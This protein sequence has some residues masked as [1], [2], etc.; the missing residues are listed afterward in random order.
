MPV[1]DHRMLTARNVALSV[2]AC[3]ITTLLVTPLRHVLAEANIVMLFLWVV[4]WLSA[5]LGRA[6]GMTAAFCSVALFD[7]FFVEPRFSFSVSDVQYLLTFAVMLVVA[8]SISSLTLHLRERAD[9]AQVLAMQS[10]ALYELAKSLSSSLSVEQVLDSTT[11]FLKNTLQ[12]ESALVL[13]DPKECLHVQGGLDLSPVEV[14]MAH[15]TFDDGL[16]K[17]MGYHNDGDHSSTYL[18]LQGST[19]VRGV[20]VARTLATS[21]D[22][23]LNHRAMLEAVASIVS[24][25]IERLHF[26][27]VAQHA[28]LKMSN[29]RLRSSILSALSHDIRTPLT[30]LYGMADG[31]HF[32]EP[33]L[34]QVVLNTADALCG[35]VMQLNTMVCNLLEMAKFQAGALVLRREWLP[36]EEVI[37]ASIQLLSSA[38]QPHGV[39]VNLPED[40]PLLNVDAVLLERVFCNLLENASKYSPQNDSPFHIHAREVGDDVHV[41][42]DNQGDAI[43]EAQLKTIFKLFE[44]GQVESSVHGTGIGLSICRSIVEAHGGRIWAENLQDGVRMCFS[45][46]IGTPPEVNIIDEGC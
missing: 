3:I 36:I 33:P 2:A 34:P 35:Q 13:P 26:V 38:I 16:I 4:V 9:D 44:R 25:S 21:A 24:A 7:L 28:Q 41:S 10:H 37:G 22:Q 17:E 31:L 40:L 29:E 43:P 14:L 1:I 27:D 45:L 30:A 12:L 39:V 32:I 46:P 20:L 18:P 6:A 19:R 11:H 8:L 5:K 15:T 42:V 23:L